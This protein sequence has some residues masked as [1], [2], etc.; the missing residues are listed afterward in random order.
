MSTVTTLNN[1]I[2][3]RVGTYTSAD[4]LAFTNLAVRTIAKKLLSLE[5]EMA[6]KEGGFSITLAKED[7]YA[8]LPSDFWALVDRPYENG[9]LYSLSPVPNQETI[10][11]YKPDVK[12]SNQGVL[13]YPAATTFK[14]AG[15][16]FDDWKNDGTATTTYKVKVTNSDGTV[17]WGYIGDIVGVDDTTITVYTDKDL[18]TAGWNGTSPSGKTPSSYQVIYQTTGTPTYYE[19]IGK[20]SLYIYPPK[21]EETIILGEYYYMPTELTVV[22]DTIPYGELFDDAIEEYI[23]KVMRSGY[24][25]EDQYSVAVLMQDFLWSAVDRIALKRGKRAPKDNWDGF[26]S[27]EDFM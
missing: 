20:S 1:A 6:K 8:T 22:G 15:Q 7:A 2:K 13:T 10:L 9:K 25:G 4:L 16:D 17:S 11:K 23:V 19:L 24:T 14:D 12:D 5:S 26:I 3:A 27:Y 18:T 21:S